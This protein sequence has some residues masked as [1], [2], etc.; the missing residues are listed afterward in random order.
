MMASIAYSRT[1]GQIK[2]AQI[3]ISS[4]QENPVCLACSE[5]VGVTKA[6]DSDDTIYLS[7]AMEITTIFPFAA[8]RNS[9]Y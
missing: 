5:T 1:R 9:A 7:M 6:S 3:S 8:N 2:S 4:S